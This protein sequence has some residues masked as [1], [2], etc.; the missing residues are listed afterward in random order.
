MRRLLDLVKGEDLPVETRLVRK[1]PCRLSLL[2][3]LASALVWSTALYAQSAPRANQG[4]NIESPSVVLNDPTV[5]R[6]R[7]LAGRRTDPQLDSIT[8][9][10]DKAAAV[11]DFKIVH[12]AVA[13]CRAALATYPTEPKVIIAH[14][15]ASDAL[16]VLALG[17][18]FPD[19]NELAFDVILKGTKTWQTSP[20]LIKQTLSFFHASAYEYGVGTKPNLSEAEKWYA[21][22]AEA[23]DPISK[24]E[25]MRLRG[26]KQ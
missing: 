9:A 10:V 4:L 6:C 12:D 26:S 2:V 16:S 5:K 23:G 11:F 7:L 19:S 21:V 24:R 15:N 25:L 17:I 1:S 14:S 13:T 8:T 22:A 3:V 20:N 18:R